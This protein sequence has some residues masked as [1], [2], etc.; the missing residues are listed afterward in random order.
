MEYNIHLFHHRAHG[1]VV[2]DITFNNFYSSFR[3]VF[4]FPG[5]EVVEYADPVSVSQ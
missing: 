3:N 5:G 2:A 4:P 1:V